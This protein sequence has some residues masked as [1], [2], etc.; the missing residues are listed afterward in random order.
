M[1]FISG[2]WQQADGGFAGG[3]FAEL[4]EFFGFNEFLGSEFYSIISTSQ[5]IHDFS[6]DSRKIP[7]LILGSRGIHYFH[8]HQLPSRQ[9]LIIIIILHKY[10]HRL[11]P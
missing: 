8:C 7:K 1:G 6:R 2:G 3:I 9:S 5:E 10:C 4:N 11:L